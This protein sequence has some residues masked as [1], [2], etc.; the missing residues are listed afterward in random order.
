MSAKD[1]RKEIGLRMST[2]R[3]AK[4][5]TQEA[6]ADYCGIDRSYI[7]RIETGKANTTIFFLDVIITALECGYEEFFNTEYFKLN[8]LKA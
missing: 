6:F 7:G 1:T 2:L 3:K 5:F 4:G 8:P